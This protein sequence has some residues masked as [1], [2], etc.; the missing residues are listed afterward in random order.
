MFILI[1]SSLY[2]LWSRL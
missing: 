1:Q 2:S